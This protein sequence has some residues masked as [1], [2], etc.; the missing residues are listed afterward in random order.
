MADLEALARKHEAAKEEAADCWWELIEAI[1]S[2]Q[3]NGA[4]LAALCRRTG[5]PSPTIMAALT[6]QGTNPMLAVHSPEC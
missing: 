1:R 3:H 2:E 4:S 5:L 6:C